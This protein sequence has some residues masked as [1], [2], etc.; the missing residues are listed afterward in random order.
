MDLYEYIKRK[1]F[2]LLFQGDYICILIEKDEKNIL[3][4]KGK[5]NEE[6]VNK[7]NEM[8]ITE[9]DDD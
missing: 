6:L 9:I 2:K 7:F 5:S 1:K 8:N 4:L 3:F